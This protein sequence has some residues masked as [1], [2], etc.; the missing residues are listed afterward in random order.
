VLLEV[1][2]RQV[3][4]GDHQCVL[5]RILGPVDIARIRRAIANRRSRRA[6]VRSMKATWSPRR[7]AITSSRSTAD[8]LMTSVGDVV[9]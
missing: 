7:A 2:E 5:Q 8:S 3:T 6:R 9:Q 4:P 1:I